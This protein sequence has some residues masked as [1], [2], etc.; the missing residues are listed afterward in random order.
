ML[1]VES[2]NKILLKKAFDENKTYHKTKLLLKIYR[3][4]VWSMTNRIYEFEIEAQYNDMEIKHF[5]EFLNFINEF[6]ININKKYLESELCCIAE[7]KWFIDI[8]DKSLTK[9]KSYPEYG[10]DYYNIVYKQYIGG[11]RYSEKNIIETL[12]VERTTFYKRKKEAI[13]LMGIILWGYVLPSLK[14]FWETN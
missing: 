14:E 6:D 12:N 3:D 8:I 11:N 5:A 4:V 2:N 9:L 13:N 7:N 1:K 10:N